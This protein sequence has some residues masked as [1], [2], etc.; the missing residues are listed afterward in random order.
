M[1]R[2]LSFIRTRGFESHIKFPGKVTFSLFREKL[3][4][5]DNNSLSKNAFFLC[6]IIED[7]NDVINNKESISSEQYSEELSEL[8]DAFRDIKQHNH[9]NSVVEILLMISE[10]TRRIWKEFKLAN[11]YE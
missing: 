8:D 11:L 5:A 6:K 1:V 3:L 9:I 4:M 2:S 10:D 7:V